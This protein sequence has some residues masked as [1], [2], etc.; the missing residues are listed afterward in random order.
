MSNAWNPNWKELADT[1]LWGNIWDK[2]DFSDESE[3]KE[4]Y[5]LLKPEQKKSVCDANGVINEADWFHILLEMEPKYHKKAI[6]V[7]LNDLDAN[8]SDRLTS[9]IRHDISTN[10]WEDLKKIYDKIGII[11][12]VSCGEL[13]IIN[14]KS[15]LTEMGIDI[16]KLDYKELWDSEE[17]Y[18][19]VKLKLP[20]EFFFAMGQYKLVYD[21]DPNAFKTFLGYGV[22]QQQASEIFASLGVNEA[23]ELLNSMPI[24]ATLHQLLINLKPFFEHGE[25]E[26][27]VDEFGTLLDL[28]YNPRLEGGND[29]CQKLIDD[30]PEKD[31]IHFIHSDFDYLK[32]KSLLVEDPA[33]FFDELLS[34]KNISEDAQ[35]LIKNNSNLLSKISPKILKSFYRRAVEISNNVPQP[36]RAP[37]Q[38]L[39]KN[40]VLN[41]YPDEYQIPE[42][43]WA[44]VG[45]SQDKIEHFINVVGMDN[46]SDDQLKKL[47][48]TVPRFEK[49]ETTPK[50]SDP[51]MEDKLELLRLIL[52]LAKAPK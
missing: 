6:D 34:K 11:K 51:V 4:W 1:P 29:F 41:A 25:A 33:K 35:D 46:F 10:A 49:Y 9:V 13:K 28:Y 3:L 31:L 19:G 12:F 36:H 32:Y 5:P 23:V 20:K 47:L 37:F 2:F 48:G 17:E 50:L 24:D 7:A 38:K 18:G 16:D 26:L 15:Y 27:N 8:N 30:L 14:I 42:H 52:P 44:F 43:T 22:Y 40:I 21:L 39:L 45:E